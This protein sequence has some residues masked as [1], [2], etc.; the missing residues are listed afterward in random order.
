MLPPL[1]APA[2]PPPGA[3]FCRAVGSG[4]R[5]LQS[6]MLREN[7][8]SSKR[9]CSVGTVALMLVKELRIEDGVK[10][11]GVVAVYH[12]T[13]D[14][15][16][17]GRCIGILPALE[18]FAL[19]LVGGCREITPPLTALLCRRI[20]FWEGSTPHG[21]LRSLS[22]DAGPVHGNHCV[23]AAPAGGDCHA[24]SGKPHYPCQGRRCGRP[25]GSCMFPF[26]A[27]L[28]PLGYQALPTAEQGDCGIDAMAFW[29]GKERTETA[30]AGLR[31]EVCSALEACAEDSIWHGIL[32]AYGEG[33][34]KVA[35]SQVSSADAQQCVTGP[36]E[37][38]PSHVAA[39]R[40]YTEGCSRVQ[41]PVRLCYQ[42]PSA[43]EEALV[44]RIVAGLGL[45]EKASIVAAHM[46]VDRDA[47]ALA[48]VLAGSTVP[49]KRHRPWPLVMQ[50]TQA[51]H[52]L[53]WCSTAGV[54]PMQE[55]LPFGRVA[56]YL[57]NHD[58]LP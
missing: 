36:T 27:T 10:E 38:I 41:T 35:S 28:R 34:A 44:S 57:Q 46:S 16:C 47:S 8:S 1:P 49:I 43:S 55:R 12:L 51:R 11:K 24:N 22:A 17:T 23:I 56:R 58:L 32:E 19:A 15:R 37:P 6:W 31:M 30:W 13:R 45:E 52:F 3:Q 53:D 40:Q 25:G 50:R 42:L 20:V 5:L 2:A 18:T 39:G 21:V 54:D 4:K 26:M 29:D 14:T 7:E 9:A 48:P 33:P